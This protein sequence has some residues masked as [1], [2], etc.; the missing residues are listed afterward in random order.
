VGVRRR[1]AHVTHRLRLTAAVVA[2]AICL[3]AL[4][5][6]QDLPTLKGPVTDLAN[7]LDDST[8]AELDRRLR[9]LQT[10]TGDAIVIVTVPTVAPFGT[11]EEYAVRLFERAGIG[12]RAQDTGALLL[13]AVNDR[14]VRI[15]V[16]Y[17]LEEFITDGFA[18]E[19]IRRAILPAFRQGDY[20]GGVLAGTTRLIQ[21]IAERR[22]VT[23][24]DMP[25]E[26]APA[27]RESDGPPIGL[28]IFAF[29]ILMM[30]GRIGRRRRRRRWWDP[31][32]GGPRIGGGWHGGLGGFGGGL[33]GGFGGGRRG[34]GGGFGGFGGFGG[35]MSGGGGATGRW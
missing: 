28:L 22:G 9:A 11:I 4:A 5:Q 17:G 7:V 12:D 2:A 33:G 25:V 26:T 30:I 15:E 35:G 21:R 1:L 32:I 18:G 29:I 24:P 14:Q 19:T 6:A 34:G 27:R 3:P 20:G 16:G 13:V 31:F 8:E 23:I 10:T